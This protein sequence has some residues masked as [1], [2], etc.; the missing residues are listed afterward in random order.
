MSATITPT[1]RPLHVR[2]L[3]PLKRIYWRYRVRCAREDVKHAR[4]EIAVL[5]GSR[6]PIDEMYVD[7]ARQQ[8][9][10]FEQAIV[11]WYRQIEASR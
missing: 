6:R 3:G 7:Y 1:V 5:G 10:V 8:I 4:H 2:A 9:A 11:H